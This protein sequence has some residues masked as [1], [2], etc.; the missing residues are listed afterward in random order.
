MAALRQQQ[1]HGRG[2]AP[3]RPARPPRRP[4]APPPGST[5]RRPGSCRPA[6]GR[7]RLRGTPARARTF[8]VLDESCLRRPVGSPATMDGQLAR[9]VEF[10]ALPNTVLQIAPF[11]R[12]D[13]RPLS[14]PLYVLT[15]QN[16]S[17]VSYAE[18]AQ[19]GQLE[20]ESAAVVPLLTAY[21]QLQA[22]ALS[23]AAS[24]AVIEQLRK[25]TP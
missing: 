19:R 4:R 15:M 18:S 5:S 13:R 24:V 21:H 17:P 14:L 12:G 3:L 9:L 22:E 8:V 6:G 11:D 23:Q 2:A 25:G 10:A 16:R 20:R 1:H 7:R